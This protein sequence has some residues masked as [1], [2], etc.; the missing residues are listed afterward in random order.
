MPNR[1]GCYSRCSNIVEQLPQLFR[2]IK[3]EQLPQLFRKTKVEQL[4]QLFRK[5]KL[6]QLPQL[7]RTPVCYLKPKTA[8]RL[9]LA[10]SW[11]RTRKGSRHSTNNWDN[12]STI[13]RRNWYLHWQPE[14]Y[15]GCEQEENFRGLWR[16]DER[17]RV[18]FTKQGN[19]LS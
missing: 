10:N 16:N 1:L 7:F 8:E 11:S 18:H 13:V 6:E 17:L 15:L 19:Q 14:L 4:P 3:V 5:I 9:I 2:K 12:G